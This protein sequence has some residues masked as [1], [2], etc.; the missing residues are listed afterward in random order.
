MHSPPVDRP[1][2]FW[3]EGT[4]EAKMCGRSEIFIHGC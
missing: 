1:C 3:I 4:D 2:S